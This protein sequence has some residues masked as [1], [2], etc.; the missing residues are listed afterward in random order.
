LD[1]KLAIFAIVLPQVAAVFALITPI[2][3]S[4]FPILAPLSAIPCASKALLAYLTAFKNVIAPAIVGIKIEAVV[5]KLIT[6][7]KPLASGLVRVVIVPVKVY[8]D[9]ATVPATVPIVVKAPAKR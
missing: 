1:N 5:N 4:Y 2:S 9:M 8:T 6:F 7:S 3:T